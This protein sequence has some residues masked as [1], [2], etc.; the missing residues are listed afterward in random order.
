LGVN[1]YDLKSPNNNSAKIHTSNQLAATVQIYENDTKKEDGLDSTQIL[2][3]S[4]TN[5]HFVNGGVSDDAR[6]EIKDNLES[7][8]KSVYIDHQYRHNN[9][10]TDIYSGSTILANNTLLES[11]DKKMHRINKSKKIISA[12]GSPITNTNLTEFSTKGLQTGWY[13]SVEERSY[14]P[15]SPV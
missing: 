12:V 6:I 15:I 1:T 5:D 2:P 3:N 11:D 8:Q 7:E 14:L 9:T 10:Q 13:C 4:D